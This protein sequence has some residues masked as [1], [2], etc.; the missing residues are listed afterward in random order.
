[1]NGATILQ[2]TSYGGLSPKLG[3]SPYGLADFNNDG[4]FDMLWYNSYTGDIQSWNINGTTVINKRLWGTLS[5]STGWFPIGVKDLNGNGYADL[6]IYNI[7]TGYVDAWLD[8]GTMPRYGKLLINNGWMPIGLEDFNGDL[9]SDLL[10]YNKHTGDLDVWYI[11][12][13]TLYD[14]VSLGKNDINSGLAIAG[15]SDFNGDGRTDILWYNGFTGETKAWLT[16]VSIVNY[17]SKLPTEGWRPMGLD[18]FNGDGKA[19]LLW[20]NA[21]T[22]E[23]ATWLLNGTGIQQTASYGPI[24]ASSVWTINIP[25]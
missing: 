4:K 22:N 7:Y 13:S 3:W 12:G 2:K 1:M 20:F 18:D 23:T 24:P 6:L 17:G 14:V 5:P 21:F 25:R 10:V 11:N 9:K 8:N 16:G 19:D 15:F